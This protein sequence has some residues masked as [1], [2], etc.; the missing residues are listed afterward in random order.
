MHLEHKMKIERK[1]FNAFL[2]HTL[3]EKIS[4][5]YLLLNKSDLNVMIRILHF[6]RAVDI[7]L[8]TNLTDT[9]K[10]PS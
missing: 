1:A 9:P 5:F 4:A 7:R 2:L 8:N 3:R 6:I 10:F